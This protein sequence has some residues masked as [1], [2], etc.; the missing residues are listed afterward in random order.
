MSV[1]QIDVRRA[2][3]LLSNDGYTYIDVRS[4]PEYEQGH[5]AGAHNVPL[6]HLE[7]ATGRM[8]PNADFL[9][10]MQANYPTD[11]KLLIGC[12]M[13]G[14]SSQA[15]QILVS[16]GY[17]ELSNVVGGFGGMKDPATGQMRA[18]GWTQAELPVETDATPDGSYLELQPKGD[19]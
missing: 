18:E 4:V 9:Q 8:V 1:K 12:Q 16:A 10:V 17:T 7:S 13:G 19:V 5:P 15:A 3:N 6:L 11:T 14:R 2:Y